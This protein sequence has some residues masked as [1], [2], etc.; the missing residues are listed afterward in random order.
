MKSN[1][2]ILF[3]I[4]LLVT[5]AFVSC[6]KE[7]CTDPLAINYFSKVTKDDGSCSYSSTRMIGEY[8]YMY[9]TLEKSA[10]VYPIDISHMKVSGMFDEGINDFNLVIR[11]SDRTMVMPDTLLPDDMRLN[12]T[13]ADKDNFSCTLTVDPAGTNMDTIYYYSFKRI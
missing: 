11:W 7:G 2:L 1:A 8:H 6:K 5:F 9:D 12:G 13:I 4:S 3:G 10:I